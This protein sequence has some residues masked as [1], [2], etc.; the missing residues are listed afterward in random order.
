MKVDLTLRPLTKKAAK[1]KAGRKRKAGRKK[2]GKA[3]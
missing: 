1:T 2:A 3:R